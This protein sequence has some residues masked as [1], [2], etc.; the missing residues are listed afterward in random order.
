[1]THCYIVVKSSQMAVKTIAAPWDEKKFILT[2]LFCK[3]TRSAVCREKMLTDQ[4]MQNFQK[5]RP[6]V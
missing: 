2:P 6:Q 1:M 4:A 3:C 5:I